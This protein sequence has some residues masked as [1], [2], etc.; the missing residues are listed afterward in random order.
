MTMKMSPST[1][2]IVAI[3]A[4][5]SLAFAAT[6]YQKEKA[7]AV[8]TQS[9]CLYAGQSYGEGSIVRVTDKTLIQCAPK[10]SM[11]FDSGLT[12]LAWKV[13]EVEET[14]AKPKK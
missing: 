11:V 10:S 4:T 6:P 13:L 3:A 5:G 9:Q 8:P 7:D 2:A 1:V 12:P 14:Q